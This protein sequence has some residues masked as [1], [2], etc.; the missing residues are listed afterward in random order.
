VGVSIELRALRTRGRDAVTRPEPLAPAEVAEYQRNLDDNLT[1]QQQAELRGRDPAAYEAW[2]NV[3]LKHVPM[4]S[5]QKPDINGFREGDR[6]RLVRPFAG[7]ECSFDV[8]R[9]GTL[10]ITDTSPAQ[11][12]LARDG[13]Y[14]VFVDGADGRLI[15]VTE[16]SIEKI[17]GHA[18]VAYDD[19]YVSVFPED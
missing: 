16:G 18:R 1:G 5:E 11:I 19:E 2:L 10:L 9:T 17:S 15:G 7:E 14:E 13:F 8:G 3:Q 4:P 6:V 12:R